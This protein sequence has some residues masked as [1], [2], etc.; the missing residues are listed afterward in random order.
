MVEGLSHITMIVSDLERSTRME[1]DIASY[2]V[3]INELGLESKEDRPRIPGEGRSIYFYD[4]DNH[5]FELHTGTLEER[6]QAY[7]EEGFIL[8]HS[9]RIQ[10]AVRHGQREIVRGKTVSLEELLAETD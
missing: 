1:E 10:R 8:A 6:L 7:R 3:R 4:Y 9:P 2:L 5:L